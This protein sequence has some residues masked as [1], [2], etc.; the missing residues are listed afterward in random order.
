L[1]RRAVAVHGDVRNS[2][3]LSGALEHAV[4]G[5]G[6]LDVVCANAGIA[7]YASTAD[8]GLSERQWRAAIDVNLTGVW[9][10]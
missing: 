10:T 3:E 7:T 9:N 1:G 6:R 5:F 4:A 2:E 8:Q